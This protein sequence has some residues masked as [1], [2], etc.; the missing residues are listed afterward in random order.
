MEIF[1][2]SYVRWVHQCRWHC[3]AIQA[4]PEA[5]QHVSRRN[6]RPIYSISELL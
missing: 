3:W 4:G 2:L 5:H 1:I 6:E